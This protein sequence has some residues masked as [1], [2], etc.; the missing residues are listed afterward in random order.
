MSLGGL[1]GV[2]K[3]Y[4]DGKKSG[5]RI[6]VR[7]HN[8]ATTAWGDRRGDADIHPDDAAGT[9]FA[10]GFDP[11]RIAD[12]VG[13]S[14]RAVGGAGE[15]N[16]LLRTSVRL[17]RGKR[18]IQARCG[19]G[20]D[21]LPG[22]RQAQNGLDGSSVDRW[23]TLRKVPVRPI[24]ENSTVTSVVS[25]GG[26]VGRETSALAPQQAEATLRASGVLPMLETE[27]TWRIVASPGWSPKSTFGVLQRAIG[28][29]HKGAVAN[30]AS[31]N[32][33]TGFPIITTLKPAIA[34]VASASTR[35]RYHNTKC[36]LW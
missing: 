31:Q 33:M 32:T 23:I 20:P 5:R 4:G 16:G 25:D 2:V 1:G 29:A 11:R 22:Q 18:Q 10:D 26:I 6:H 17:R 12:D 15:H 30:A 36:G 21:H 28:L 14:K 9:G 8:R 27:K 34:R 19:D 35:F 13:D 7:M 3:T 24:S